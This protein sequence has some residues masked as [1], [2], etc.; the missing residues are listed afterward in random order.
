MAT[1]VLTDAFISMNA[2]DESEHLTSI[3][4]DFTAETQPS[5]GFGDDWMEFEGG[6]KGVTISLDFNQD[7]DAG[8]FDSRMF[9]LLGDEVCSEL[10][11]GEE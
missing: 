11:G 9:L 7:F 3:G 8:S 6:L 10:P 1:K 5:T 2:V 4:V